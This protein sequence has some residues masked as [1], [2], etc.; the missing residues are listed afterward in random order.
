MAREPNQ[1]VKDKPESPAL[2]PVSEKVTYTPGPGDNSDTTWMGHKFKAHVPHDLEIPGADVMEAMTKPEA[3]RSKADVLAILGLSKRLKTN[4]HLVIAARGN[5]FFHVGEFDPQKHA[6]KEVVPEPKTAEA[7]RAWCVTWL[8]DVGSVDELCER[9]ANEAKMRA[10]LEVGYDDLKYIST[11]LQPKL[12]ELIRRE[13]EPRRVRDELIRKGD[14]ADLELQ[15][16][17]VGQAAA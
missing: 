17:G 15:I 4:A 12:D 13:D 14:L 10:R 3:E 9:W 16:A 1:T 8:R 2:L 6:Y 5:K 11:L 7:Y